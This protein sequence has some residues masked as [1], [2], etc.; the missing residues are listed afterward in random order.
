MRIHFESPF[1]T[2]VPKDARFSSR[3]R[4]R[5]SPWNV[6]PTFCWN[7]SWRF[8]LSKVTTGYS[9]PFD[10]RVLKPQGFKNTTARAHEEH[11]AADRRL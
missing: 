1:R 3:S 11:V 6:R 4:L 7:L 5:S 9:N 10:R 8:Y 2:S